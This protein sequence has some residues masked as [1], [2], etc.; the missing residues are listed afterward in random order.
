M[1]T[2]GFSLLFY[3]GLG[4]KNQER[5]GGEMTGFCYFQV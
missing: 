5:G 3:V 1:V 2:H 4:G